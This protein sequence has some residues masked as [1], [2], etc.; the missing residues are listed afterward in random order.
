MSDQFTNCDLYLA[1]CRG[2]SAHTIRVPQTEHP[3][4]VPPFWEVALQLRFTPRARLTARQGRPLEHCPQ[5]D[6][7]LELRVTQ[8]SVAYIF[9][10]LEDLQPLHS[11]PRNPHLLPWWR[12]QGW[13]FLVVRYT[14]SWA[15]AKADDWV[16]R[17]VLRHHLHDALAKLVAARAGEPLPDSGAAPRR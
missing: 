15:L 7:L 12:F 3:I 8:D 4:E 14:A 5:T 16:A 17:C 6:E 11:L 13:Q 10:A 2:S 9:D 1:E